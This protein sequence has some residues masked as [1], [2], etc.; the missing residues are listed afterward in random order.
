MKNPVTETQAATCYEWHLRHLCALCAPVRGR[1]LLAKNRGLCPFTVN[2]KKNRSVVSLNI[3]KKEFA[4]YK[5]N[6]RYMKTLKN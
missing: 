1:G 6:L 3:R 4:S 5:V 2:D